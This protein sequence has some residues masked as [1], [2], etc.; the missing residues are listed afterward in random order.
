MVGWIQHDGGHK[1]GHGGLGRCMKPPTKLNATTQS[2]RL[3]ALA[4]SG[5]NPVHPGVFPSICCRPGAT[6]LCDRPV[7][8]SQPAKVPSCAGRRHALAA[9]APDELPAHRRRFLAA[10]HCEHRSPVQLATW[11]SGSRDSRNVRLLLFLRWRAMRLILVSF[12]DLPQEQG[13]LP[14]WILLVAV[15]A[16]FNTAQNF[17]TTKLSSRLYSTAGWNC[18]LG[19]DFP[20][21]LF[22]PDVVTPL[23]ARTFAVW[24][25]MSA[26]VRGYAAYNIQNK[27]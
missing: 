2:S 14:K 23:Q 8:L 4:F 27:T 16:T 18:F 25:L 12:I 20:P 5:K 13:L 7:A 9:S 22:F 1:L 21:F 11:R 10:A 6:G 3:T 17:A 15:M 24:T 19:S 26:I